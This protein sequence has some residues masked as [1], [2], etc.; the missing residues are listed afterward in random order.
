MFNEKGKIKI[1]RR[2]R[3]VGFISQFTTEIL[4]ISVISN[5]VADALSRLENNE[6]NVITVEVDVD[7]IC[8]EKD[9][10]V[11][12]MRKNGFRDHLFNEVRMKG[13]KLIF[14]RVFSSINRPIVPRKLRFPLFLQINSLAH[15]GTK[16]MLKL[17]RKKYFWPNMTKDIST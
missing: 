16:S 11:N 8:E 13:N 2:A 4:H 6:V 17:I 14:R 1:E 15:L 5:I 9:P 10:E 3:Q 7:K 12:N